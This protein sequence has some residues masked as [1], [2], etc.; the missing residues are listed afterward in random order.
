MFPPCSLKGRRRLR[1]L[2]RPVGDIG[3]AIKLFLKAMSA[4][5]GCRF[6]WHRAVRKLSAPAVST[7]VAGHSRVTLLA[8]CVHSIIIFR[9]SGI[10]STATDFVRISV[11]ANIPDFPKISK[12]WFGP[13]RRRF[14]SFRRP[15]SPIPQTSPS[16]FQPN[17]R[18]FSVMHREKLCGRG[19]PS[20]RTP[21]Q[22]PQD[23][24]AVLHRA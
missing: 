13:G 7:R 17:G 11:T 19:Q 24:S 14:K 10:S 2:L 15:F 20:P 22:S 4:Q 16:L 21:N 6:E 18:R 5:T 23:R 8:V 1:T 9:Y 12:L 3:G